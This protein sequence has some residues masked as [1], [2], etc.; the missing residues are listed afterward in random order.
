MTSAWDSRGSIAAPAVTASRTPT[1]ARLSVDD[2]RWREFVAGRPEATAFHLPAWTA[3]LADC[4]GFTSFALAAH[5]NGRIV[6]GVPVIETKKPFRKQRWVSLPFTDECQLLGEPSVSLDE[7]FDA[8]RREA[9]VSSFEIRGVLAGGHLWPQGYSHRLALQGDLDALTRGYRSSVRQSIR[10][11][12]REGVRIRVADNP[13]DLT[14]IF[15]SLHVS[16][17]R[18]LG[19]PVQRLRYFRLLWERL[20]EPGHGFVMIAERG[21]V[22]LAAAVFLHSNGNVLYKYGASDA[23][24]WRLR[25]NNALFQAAITRSVE[26]GFHIFDWGRTSFEDEGLRRFKAAW[27]SQETK[28][29]YSRLG[30]SPAPPASASQHKLA[31]GVIRRSPAAVCRIAGAL[32]YRYAA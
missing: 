8:A 4:Y 3:F 22:P 28:L 5:E 12:A 10:V 31:R 29:T 13:A 23:E 20:I 9:E 15:H 14:G 26:L 17:R 19:V 32:L 2:P 27:G 1:L 24:H 18:R 30:G 16:T 7:E 25:A 21:R 11:A 6:A